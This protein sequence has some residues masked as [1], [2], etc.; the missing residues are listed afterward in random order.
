MQVS[1]KV[2][3]IVFML[4]ML[5]A[6]LFGAQF[7]FPAGTLGLQAGNVNQG[8]VQGVQIN[9]KHIIVPVANYDLYFPA[10]GS[11]PD[12]ADAGLW[13]GA[14]NTGHPNDNEVTN[15]WVRVFGGDRAVELSNRHGIPG[16]DNAI[17][18]G[19]DAAGAQAHII[20]VAAGTP[21]GFEQQFWQTFRI[22]ASNPVGRVLLYRLLIEIRRMDVAGDGCCE[23]GINII[24]LN[25][26]NICRSITI[27]NSHD[28]FCFDSFTPSIEFDLNANIRTLTL[29]LNNHNELTTNAENRTYDIA[30]FHEM[31]HWFHSLRNLDSYDKLASDDPLEFKYPLRCYYGKANELIIWAQAFNIDAEE[32][33]TILGCPNLNIPNLLPFI[34]NNAFFLHRNNLNDRRVQINGVNQYIPIA[35][36]YLNGDDLSE[37]VYRASKR[38]HMRFGHVMIEIESLSYPQ[39][40]N[41]FNL[42]REIVLE[43]YRQITN[44][45]LRNWRLIHGEA[46][47]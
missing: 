13:S 17:L 30:L 32:I 16:V 2:L 34:A 41:R 14:R 38:R 5:N 45:P 42:A 43:C 39:V 9:C 3:H 29:D 10:D 35:E 27:V 12:T 36:T 25:D 22:I 18:M 15:W 46:I 44:V 26:R 47:Q 11:Q 6:Y 37:N 23:D 33:A 28:G 20:Q 1:S 7:N 31:L 8:N 24:D 4:H 21:V 19:F 40:P